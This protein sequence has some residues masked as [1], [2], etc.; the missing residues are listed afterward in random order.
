MDECSCGV[1]RRKFW[2]WR[3]GD[4]VLHASGF[5]PSSGEVREVIAATARDALLPATDGGLPKHEVTDA[6]DQSVLWTSRCARVV[7]SV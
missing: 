3:D 4:G 1:Q 7:G 6:R 2:L 5:R